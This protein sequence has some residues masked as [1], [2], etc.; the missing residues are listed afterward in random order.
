[1]INSS[2]KSIEPDSPEGEEIELE[3]GKGKISFIIIRKETN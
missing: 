3:A 1:L 2:E